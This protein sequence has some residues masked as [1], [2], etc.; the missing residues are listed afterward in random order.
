MDYIYLDNAATTKMSKEVVEEMNYINQNEYGN[1]SSLHR[2]G[3]IAEKRIDNANQIISKIINCDSDEIIWTSGGTESNNLAILGYVYANRHYGNHIITTKIE[4]PSVLNVIKHLENN[5]Y[6]V[7]YLD[8]DKNGLINLN[9]FENLIT[10]NTLLVSI[11]FVNNEIGTIEKISEISKIIKKK[12]KHIA[13][14][15]D[16]VQGFGK[17]KIDVKDLGID[18]MSTSAHKI[19]AA[20]GVGFLYKNK[21]IKINNI[22]FGGGQQNNLRSGTLNTAGIVGFAKF[23]NIIYN[24]FDI[25]NNKIKELK[26]YFVEKINEINKFLDCIIINSYDEDVFIPHIVSLSIKNVRAEVLIHSLEEKNIYVSAGSACS[27]KQKKMSNTLT[28]IGLN[29]ELIENTIRVSFSIYNEIFEIDYFVD[30]L[31]E[32]IK[33][34]QKYTRR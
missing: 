15:V 18:M 9:E 6:K 3:Y 34:L 21:N 25:Y 22:L 28:A 24:D 31:K 17:L 33:N 11:M 4:H 14:H 1:S 23:A 8:V 12:N 26:K 19:H 16:A 32:L 27:S 10:E 20:K 2:F 30:I 13:F 7:S 29:K 5:G